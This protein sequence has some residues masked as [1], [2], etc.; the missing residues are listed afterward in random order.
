MPELPSIFPAERTAPFDP[1]EEYAALAASRC[2]MAK[3]RLWNDRSIWL[4]VGYE[5][6]RTAL[7]DDRFSADRN[8]PHYPLHNRQAVQLQLR[9]TFIGQDGEPHARVRRVLN[10]DF[11]INSVQQMRPE[12]ERIVD[13]YLDAMAEMT[14]PVDLCEAFAL[15][16]PSHVMCHVLGIPF[17]DGEYFTER[18]HAVLSNA[19]DPQLVIDAMAD[20]RGYLARLVESKQDNLGDDV[21]SRLLAERGDTFSHEEIITI[22]LLLRGAGHETT[23]NMI[24]LSTFALLEHPEQRDLLLARE[25]LAPQAVEELLRYLSIF[26]HGLGRVVTGDI[27]LGGERLKPGDGVISMI[28]VANR[29]AGRFPAPDQ[30]DI[31]NAEAARG[32]LA[33]GFGAHN[34]LGKALARLELEVALTH[35][36]RR[37]P[38]LRLAVPPQDVKLRTDM[39]I[40]GVHEL[41]VTW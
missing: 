39:H 40:Y 8:N 5:E 33:F 7:R 11:S 30:L 14:P 6:A 10:K 9:D 20:L 12:I 31:T 29:D 41:P 36:L 34:C 25:D 21:I 24:G 38:G 32:H 19:S 13:Y 1:P 2:P 3:V 37:F 22:S 17:E 27:E 18:A 35:L 23:A 16:V 26:Q 4:A 28:N 15:P